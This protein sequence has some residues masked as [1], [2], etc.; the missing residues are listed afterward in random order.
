[1]IT[2][3]ELKKRVKSQKKELET[4]TKEWYEILKKYGY[5]DS[6]IEWART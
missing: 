1:M 3:T 6:E 2:K 4:L 5:S